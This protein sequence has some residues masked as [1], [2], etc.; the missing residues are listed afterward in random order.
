MRPLLVPYNP[1]ITLTWSFLLFV[2]SSVLGR[3]LFFV[4]SASFFFSSFFFNSGRTSSI[5]THTQ[6]YTRQ[7]RGDDPLR[8]STHHG[9]G[10]SFPLPAPS[11]CVTISLERDPE[12]LLAIPALPLLLLQTTTAALV[13]HPSIHPSR[14][15]REEREAGHQLFPPPTFRWIYF[16]SFQVFNAAHVISPAF[17]FVNFLVF[18]SSHAVT[19][20]LAVGFV[21]YA[22]RRPAHSIHRTCLH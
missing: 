10:G 15:S 3:P 20:H 7:R 2:L 9:G 8:E 4:F 13:R 14:G 21:I 5:D 17:L 12:S 11:C 19:W 6:G 1:I 22:G 16:Y 18:S